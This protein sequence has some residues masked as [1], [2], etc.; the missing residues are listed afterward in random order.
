MAPLDRDW[1]KQKLK[2]TWRI[3]LSVIFKAS[4]IIKT[5]SLF[6]RS[7]NFNSNI[8]IEEGGRSLCP[9]IY[10]TVLNSLRNGKKIEFLYFDLTRLPPS[11]RLNF[12]SRMDFFEPW[13][14][15]LVPELFFRVYKAKL[16]PKYSNV[17]GMLK[18]FYYGVNT[19]N[20]Y[21]HHT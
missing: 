1:N 12:S 7:Y 14:Y 8:Y 11:K 5:L 20:R 3:F 16:L 15:P 9:H 6:Y 2:V 10:V 18:I 4:R 19:Q 17:A 21:F 13:L